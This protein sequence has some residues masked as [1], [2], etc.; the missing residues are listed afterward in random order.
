MGPSKDEL[1]IAGHREAK[2]VELPYLFCIHRGE[3]RI[4]AK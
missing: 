2:A 4:I 3:N 1:I